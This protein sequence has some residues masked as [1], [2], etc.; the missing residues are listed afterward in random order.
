VY[1]EVCMSWVP[2]CEGAQTLESV[3]HDAVFM[4]SELSIVHIVPIKYLQL[5]YQLTRYD[6]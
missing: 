5:A 3:Y 6:A 2:T 1:E 4:Y